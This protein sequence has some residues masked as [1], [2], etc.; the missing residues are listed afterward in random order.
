MHNMIQITRTLTKCDDPQP[1]PITEMVIDGLAIRRGT[2]LLGGRR[3]RINVGPPAFGGLSVSPSHAA[4]QVKRIRRVTFFDMGR[5]VKFWDEKDKR[6]AFT[7]NLNISRHIRHA[8][9]EIDGPLA[10]DVVG[11]HEAHV[12]LL[13]CAVEEDIIHICVAEAQI[14]IIMR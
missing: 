13:R 3:N 1:V 2:H 14:S 7:V 4:S 9:P 5:Q 11:H 8:S 10:C 6:F 12:I